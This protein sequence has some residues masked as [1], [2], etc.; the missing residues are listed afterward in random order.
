M[1]RTRQIIVLVLESSLTS[2]D[3]DRCRDRRPT[4]TSVHECDH[5]HD[6]DRSVV[7][8][9]GSSSLWLLS[10]RTRL[11]RNLMKLPDRF[12]VPTLALLASARLPY[13]LYSDGVPKPGHMMLSVSRRPQ[14]PHSVLYSG[15]MPLL[16]PQS[17]VLCYSHLRISLSS[18][19]YHISR[20]RIRLQY[21]Q[22]AQHAQL[23]RLL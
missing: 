22:C 11:G 7:A 9:T 21:V 10:D 8:Y 3:R 18:I 14:A 20:I 16:I 4:A 23:G 2:S 12:G 17:R 1:R 6:C 15:S 13:D 5:D 19:K